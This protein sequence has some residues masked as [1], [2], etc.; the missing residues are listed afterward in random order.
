MFELSVKDTQELAQS[1]EA[2]EWGI[3][4]RADST[5]KAW[6][7]NT[8]RSGNNKQFCVA[9]GLVQLVYLTSNA[10]TF[11]TVLGLLN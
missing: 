10:S 9:L 2:V 4:G 3:P 7:L 6:N 5:S 11:P 8:A 1:R